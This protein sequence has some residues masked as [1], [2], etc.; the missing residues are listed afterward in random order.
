MQNS[1]SR[2]FFFRCFLSIIILH[3]NKKKRGH[4]ACFHVKAFVSLKKFPRLSS[5]IQKSRFYKISSCSW[6]ALKTTADCCMCSRWQLLFGEFRSQLGYNV[7]WF[8]P[9]MVFSV[10]Y[11]L[12]DHLVTVKDSLLASSWGIFSQLLA[13]LATFFVKLHQ[14][15]VWNGLNCLQNTCRSVL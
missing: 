13:R 15:K 11:S 7:M 14:A 10:V 6:S 8:A 1:F 3:W 9:D 4:Q 12:E 5:R 2:I